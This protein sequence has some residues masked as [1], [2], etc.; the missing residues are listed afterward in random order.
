[1][2]N[3]PLCWPAATEDPSESGKVSLCSDSMVV[4]SKVKNRR[5]GS[6]IKLKVGQIDH[7]AS[8]CKQ[9]EKII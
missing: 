4:S 1:M 6:Q 8:K 9:K 2:S 7:K 3:Q 5:S